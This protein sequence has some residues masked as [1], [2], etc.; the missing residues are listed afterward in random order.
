MRDPVTRRLIIA[1][2]QFQ[3]KNL[4]PA[5]DRAFDHLYGALL[6]SGTYRWDSFW[7]QA[8]RYF[9]D[10]STGPHE[11]GL[12]FNNLTHWWNHHRRSERW[13]PAEAVWND[14]IGMALQWEAQTGKRI[15]K[16]T[17]YYFWGMTA[18]LRGD[19]D[20]GYALI[21][22]ALEDDIHFSMEPQPD[23]PALALATLNADKLDQAFRP[24]VLAKTEILAEH[25]ADY[26]AAYSRALTFSDIN[27]RFLK[28][29]SVTY[30][31][32][33]LAYVLGRLR[34]MKEAPPTVFDGQFASQLHL[35]LLFDLAL[36]VDGAIATHNPPTPGGY[37]SFLDHAEFLAMSSSLSVNRQELRQA[38]TAANLNVDQ[39][40]NDLLDATFQASPTNTLRGKE[41]DLAVTYVLRNQ[42]GHGVAPIPVLQLRAAEVYRSVFRTLFLV[43]ETFYP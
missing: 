37:K 23:L 25:L 4:A 20:R 3:L 19:L 24:W 27:R 13:I 7:K 16:G 14:S 6:S 28:Q 36:V 32:F 10:P 22:K 38:N 40:L 11:H 39:T 1:G 30:P 21:H 34:K 15:H 2:A 33:I 43:I 35:N 42:G 5:M 8:F 9:S 17:P 12:F 31:V 41:R 18:I 29:A 26:C